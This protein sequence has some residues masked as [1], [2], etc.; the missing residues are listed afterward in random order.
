VF[1]SRKKSASASLSA[2]ETI[3]FKDGLAFQPSLEISF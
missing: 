2:V 3:I 1:F